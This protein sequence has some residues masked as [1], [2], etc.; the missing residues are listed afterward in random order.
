MP[1]VRIDLWAGRGPEVKQA[2]IEKVTRAVVD[3]VGCPTDAVE[4]LIYEVD[5]ANWAT[6]GVAHAQKFP[7]R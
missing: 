4:V 5:K 6:G 1:L 3:A 2:L 7:N